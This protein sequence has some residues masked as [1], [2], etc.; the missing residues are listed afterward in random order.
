MKRRVRVKIRDQRKVKKKMFLYFC[1][2]SNNN[3][4]NIIIIII[5]T[6]IIIGHIT[7]FYN[8]YLKIKWFL[9]S[10]FKSDERQ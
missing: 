7:N 6:I 4:N 2:S 10:F 1:N 5:I 3:N 9:V 8:L